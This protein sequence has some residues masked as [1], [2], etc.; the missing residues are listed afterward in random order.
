MKENKD[1]KF[2]MPPLLTSFAPQFIHLFDAP[3]HYGAD[4]ERIHVFL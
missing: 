3:Q 1:M 2:Q 4:R